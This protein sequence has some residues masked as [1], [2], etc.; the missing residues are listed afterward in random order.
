MEATLKRGYKLILLA[1]Y[2]DECCDAL[3][4]E[5]CVSMCNVVE[6]KNDTMVEVIGDISLLRDGYVATRVKKGGLYAREKS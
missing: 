1:S 2:C 5:E 4:C 3:P 6:L